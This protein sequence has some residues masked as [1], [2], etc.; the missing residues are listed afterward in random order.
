MFKESGR[1]RILTHTPEIQ[2]L[3]GVAA[4]LVTTQEGVHS[5]WKTSLDD[6]SNRRLAH[7]LVT[8]GHLSVIE[9]AM[10]TLSFENVSLFVEQFVIQF[11]LA[12]YTVKSRRYVDFASSGFY[13]PESVRRSGFAEHY[14]T[15]A[16][17]LFDCYS[18]LQEMGVPREDA[19]FVLPYCLRS[20]FLCTMNLRELCHLI[21]RTFSSPWSQYEEI[22]GLG[23][24]LRDQVIEVAPFLENTGLLDSPGENQSGEPN[25]YADSIFSYDL[26]KAP[27]SGEAEVELISH[28]PD[29][30]HLVMT[31][32]AAQLRSEGLF[33]SGP[34]Q[35]SVSDLVS[36]AK[37]DRWARNLEH[38][39]FTFAVRGLSLAALTHLTRHRMQSLCVPDLGRVDLTAR[40]V[41][42]QSIRS[43]SKAEELYSSAARAARRMQHRMSLSG[44]SERDRVYLSI[45]GNLVDVVFSMNARELIHFVALRTCNRAQWEIRKV[46]EDVLALAKLVAPCIFEGIGP[47]CVTLGY[48]PEGKLS[49][50]RLV[51]M[52]EKYGGQ[53]NHRGKKPSS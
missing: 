1:V 36:L 11:R 31:A 7:R 30:D 38:A 40:F 33:Q 4:R 5:L 9:H 32:V 39:V 8:M 42:P 48:C 46:A 6:D 16:E 29:P 13:M 19:R 3:I 20:N 22:R 17:W 41:V 21:A 43:L 37:R 12:S 23:A 52:V 50:G 26:Q 2:R 35:M 45:C 34:K 49:C 24:S 18:R 28:S 51:E 25:V 14:R 44:V 10:V 27:E 15:H 47:S 53:A